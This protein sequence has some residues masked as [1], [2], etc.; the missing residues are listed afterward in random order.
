[1]ALERLY[2]RYLEPEAETRK[3]VERLGE[4]GRGR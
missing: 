2:A 1:V 3:P 4:P